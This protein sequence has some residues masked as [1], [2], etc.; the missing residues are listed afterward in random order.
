MTLT[1]YLLED[2]TV[3]VTYTNGVEHQK[4]VKGNAYVLVEKLSSSEL[5]DNVT[6]MKNYLIERSCQSESTVGALAFR[7]TK[8][9]DDATIEVYFDEKGSLSSAA[10]R[11]IEV[12]YLHGPPSGRGQ[13]YMRNMTI[14]CP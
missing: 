4:T 7:S 14:D 6:A 8:D 11:R 1:H 9:T 10:K 5:F 3:T 2:A 12:S 13:G